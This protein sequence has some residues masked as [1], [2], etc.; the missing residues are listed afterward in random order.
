MNIQNLETVFSFTER[1]KSFLESP[2]NRMVS[3]FW[4]PVDYIAGSI[5][6]CEFNR[7]CPDCDLLSEGVEF[8][9]KSKYDLSVDNVFSHLSD[10]YK[11]N[12]DNLVLGDYKYYGDFEISIVKSSLLD[13]VETE[14]YLVVEDDVFDKYFNQDGKNLIPML[15]KGS[16]EVASNEKFHTIKALGVRENINGSAELVIPVDDFGVRFKVV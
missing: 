15:S 10:I 16:I 1:A 11:S 4:L 5:P 7:D 9:N 2:E 3:K 14:S 12:K 13:F 8:F 6:T